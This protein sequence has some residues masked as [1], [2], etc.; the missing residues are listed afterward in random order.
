MAPLPIR[1]DA[2]SKQ[3]D[4][5]VALEDIS[6][7]VRPGEV[8][9]VLGPNG[10]GKTTLV[11]TI[12]DIIR[13]DRG[14]VEVFGRPFKP[15]DRDRIGYLPE[16]RGL[17]LRQSV[18]EVL[19]Y[20]GALKGLTQRD[21][22]SRLSTWIERFELGSVVDRR[23]EQLSKGN[24]QKVQLIAALLANPLIL[25]LDEPL[26]GLDPVGARLVSSVIAECAAGGQAVLLSTHQM[27]LVEALC[28]RLFMLARGRCVLYGEVPTIKR[29]YASDVLFVQSDANYASSPCVA[30]V[31][32]VGHPDPG[33]M[34]R[35]RDG[36]SAPEF[37]RWLVASGA[38]IERFERR[39]TPLEDIFVQVVAEQQRARQ[40]HT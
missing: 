28:G 39:S 11:R 14:R 9:A 18:S 32:S 31:E 1:V 8:F 40:V 3:Y 10:A 20:L 5:V 34:I 21:V 7:E 19:S 12:L 22:R 16:E 35:L 36:V 30:Q 26:S 29:T 38:T 4:H 27:G 17:Y 13:P 25:I 33:A 6:F 15:E 37:L 23:I 24:Q 2:I